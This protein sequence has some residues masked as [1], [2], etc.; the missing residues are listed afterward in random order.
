MVDLR[1]TSDE[2]SVREVFANL[3]EKEAQRSTP[4]DPAEEGFDHQLWELL[5]SL[6]AL[7][8][9]DESS[10]GGI[11]ALSLVA[12]EAGRHLAVVPLSESA[13]VVRTLRATPGGSSLADDIEAGRLIA[14]LAL[15]PVRAGVAHHVPAGAVADVVIALDGEDLVA[16]RAG[17]VGHPRSDLGFLAVGDRAVEAGTR[18]VLLT[19]EAA[20]ESYADAVGWWRIAT[21]AGLVGLGHQAIR[22]GVEYARNRIQFGVPIG[23]FQAI[24]HGLADVATDVEGAELLAL[25]AAWLADQEAVT[26]AIWR[27]HALM[28]FAQASAAAVAA[29]SVSMHYHGGYG[30]A[31]EYPIHRY[32]RRAKGW[33]LAGG[34]PDLLWETIG[35]NYL[36]TAG[37]R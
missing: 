29:A 26:P 9:A 22:I 27:N 3:F 24:Q 16:L 7:G 35:R 28:A 10:G 23:T 34:D 37:G 1:L 31:L 8:I 18:E 14:T 30:V 33:A 15:E 19:G 11:V 25:E 13:I 4:N 32:V 21:A 17:K 2:E 36:E 6:D 12:R 5:G 20:R